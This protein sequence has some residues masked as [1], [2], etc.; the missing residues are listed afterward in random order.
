[1]NMY[2]WS[3]TDWAKKVEATAALLRPAG[4]LQPET[5]GFHL[6]DLALHGAVHNPSRSYRLRLQDTLQSLANQRYLDDWQLRPKSQLIHYICREFHQAHFAQLPLLLACAQQLQGS[7]QSR[8][9]EQL[10]LLIQQLQEDLFPHMQ[11]EEQRIF[12]ALLKPVDFDSFCSLAILHHNHDSQASLLQTMDNLCQELLEEN[13][14]Q[15]VTHFITELQ[16]F[17]MQLR[18]HIALE[19]NLLFIID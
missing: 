18:L 16:N 2:S 13:P 17:T 9:L 7:A 14:D 15:A 6:C 12:P 19:N 10:Q 11:H 5:A 3:F 4:L 1:M 8:Q